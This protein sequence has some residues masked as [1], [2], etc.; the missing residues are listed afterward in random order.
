MRT[1]IRPL[2]EAIVS[3][4]KSSNAAQSVSESGHISAHDASHR[5]PWSA[6]APINVR[7]FTAVRLYQIA[8]FDTPVAE[9]NGD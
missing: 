2:R 1:G 5:P 7:L 4:T 9:S 3:S 6:P 8:A